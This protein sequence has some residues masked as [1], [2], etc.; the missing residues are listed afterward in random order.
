MRE[1]RKCKAYLKETH[2]K[3][4]KEQEDNTR[5]ALTERDEVGS[6]VHKTEVIVQK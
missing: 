4:N 2:Q 3:L 5:K 6:M 1:G